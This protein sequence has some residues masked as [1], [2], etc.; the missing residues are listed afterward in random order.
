MRKRLIFKGYV[1]GVGF[2]YTAR[3]IANGYAVYGWVKNLPDGSVE[4]TAEGE[5]KEIR[6]FLK[7]IQQRLGSHVRETNE[8]N[9][10]ETGEFVD[11]KI[12]Y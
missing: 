6:A 4:M 8:I 7:E 9:E 12:V 11:F 1:Q 2:R 10:P 5:A 3:M